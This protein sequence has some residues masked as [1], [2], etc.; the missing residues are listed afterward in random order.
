MKTTKYTMTKLLTIGL[1]IF[2]LLTSC[3]E[4]AT[5]ADTELTTRQLNSATDFDILINKVDTFE[6]NVDVYVSVVLN[7]SK[8][9]LLRGLVDC[10]ITD[11]TTIDTT[12]F[13][14]IKGCTQLTINNDTANIWFTTGNKSGKYQFDKVTLLAKGK[15]NKYYYQGVSF[16]YIV[17]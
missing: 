14:L 16:D 15:D 12:S 2:R 7:N 3:T 9:E 1:F 5:H 11:T 10:N 17:K 6:K 4:T 13:P 8:Y